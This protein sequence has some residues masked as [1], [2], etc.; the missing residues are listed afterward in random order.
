MN[1][2][3]LFFVVVI[4]A[5][6]ENTDLDF[7]EQTIY[8]ENSGAL[9]PAYIRGN[10]ASNVFIL[11][12]HGGPGGSG[13]AYSNGIYAKMLEEKY[14]MVYLDQR[15][16]GM[17][18]GKYA[19]SDVTVNALAADVFA[20]VKTLKF[21][22]GENSKIV[23]FGHS[24]GGML[25]S[26]FMVNETYQN[27]VAGWIE[28]NGAHDLPLLNKSS[29][30]LFRKTAAEQILKG[31]SVEEWTEILS[32][33][34]KINENSITDQQSEEINEKGFE[35]ENYLRLD[36]EINTSTEGIDL[37]AFLF[38]PTNWL[39][40]FLTGNNTNKLLSD[41]I[42]TTALTPQLKNI[43]KPCL[44]LYSKYDFVVP[45]KLGETAFE[46]VSS[47]KK[48]LVIFERSGHSP[49]DAEPYLFADEISGFI[50]SL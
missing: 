43:T 22:F 42:E 23:L 18:Q 26:A 10:A 4:F 45:P 12:L 44:F 50:D 24:W 19:A 25:G 49:M 33:S 20:V 7:F 5:S 48:K 14:A 41:E 39:T 34:N 40:S 2:I 17:S 28:S 35:V 21:K 37:K 1:K 6:C 47:V 8:V 27:E 29:V 46:N 15:G 31:N 11:L 13:L 32:W 30:L 16:Q 9:M 38:G 3:L 36:D